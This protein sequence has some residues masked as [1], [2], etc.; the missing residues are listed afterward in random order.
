M[1]LATDTFVHA[2]HVR[3]LG[4]NEGCARCHD[5]PARVKHRDA[6]T[7]C[8]ECHT[9]MVAAESRI[10]LPEEGMTGI[11]AGYMDAMHGLCIKCHE[12]KIE[13]QPVN[14]GPEFAR[15]SNCHRD[16]DGSELQQTAPRVVK[17]TIAGVEPSEESG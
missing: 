16:A 9:G 2:S 8:L 11:A 3:E 6:T 14:Y 10:R 15:C 12:E 5:D 17:E 7:G 1:Y 13:N 4:G